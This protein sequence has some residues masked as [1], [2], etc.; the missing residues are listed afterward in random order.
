M[1]GATSAVC[2]GVSAIPGLGRAQSISTLASSEINYIPVTV[3]AGYQKLAAASTRALNQSTG[4]SSAGASLITAAARLGMGGAVAM[5]VFG[6][7]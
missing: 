5:A 2:T 3:T 1:H 4:T 7:V 6:V